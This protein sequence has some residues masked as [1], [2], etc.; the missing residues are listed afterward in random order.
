MQKFAT[1]TISTTFWAVEEDTRTTSTG[2]VEVLNGEQD[3]EFQVVPHGY[4][5]EMDICIDKDI[6]ETCA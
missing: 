6:G 2:H 3:E 5:N 4:K 1:S